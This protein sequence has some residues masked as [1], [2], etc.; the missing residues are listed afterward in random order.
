MNLAF[1]KVRLRLD[2]MELELDGRFEKPATALFGP[3]GAGKTSILELV[4]GL[5]RPEAG[6][7]ELDGRVLV[8]AESRVFVPARQRGVGYIPQDLA[9]FPHLTVAENIDYGRRPSGGLSREKLCQVLE[10][11]RLLDRR[12]ASLSGGEKQRVAFARALLAAPRIL[13]FDEPLAS[14]DQELKD[15]IV[16]YLERV[17]QEV[18]IPMIYVTHSASEVFRLCEEVVVLQRG[19]MAARGRPEE[20]FESFPSPA[21][22]LRD[23]AGG[24]FLDSGEPG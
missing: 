12:P 17:R 14:L 23:E 16:P 10:I 2:S 19:R 21:Y 20:I 3:S 7:I 13:L 22:R 5:R 1:H 18:A 8:D 15:R 24:R 11:E 6:R 4:A 9:L